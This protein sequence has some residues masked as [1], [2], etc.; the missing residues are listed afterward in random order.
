[1][2]RDTWTGS[3]VTQEKIGIVFRSALVTSN[4]LS[5]LAGSIVCRHDDQP[6]SVTVFELSANFG[7]RLPGL[8]PSAV[9][10]IRHTYSNAF[11]KATKER[12]KHGDDGG[13][14]PSLMAQRSSLSAGQLSWKDHPV[15]ST[16]N[17]DADAA[18]SMSCG[19]K[20][21]CPRHRQN[22]TH[23]SLLDGSDDIGEKVSVGL[24]S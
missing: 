12:S 14:L 19:G 23:R 1:M 21:F 10:K 15:L 3:A 22:V 20:F 24:E 18:M 9:P 6:A 7:G 17:V 5:N 11:R 2:C 13:T 4:V 8:S 16:P